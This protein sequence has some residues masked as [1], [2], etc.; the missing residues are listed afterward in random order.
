MGLQPG[1]CFFR[2]RPLGPTGAKVLPQLLLLEDVP[3]ELLR[4]WQRLHSQLSI[5][6]LAAFLI[7]PQGL[8][9]APRTPETADQLSMHFLSQAIHVEGLTVPGDAAV[10]VLPTCM[11]SRQHLQ[12]TQEY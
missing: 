3:I 2:R 9:P 5:Q 12:E 6:D 4:L 8:I 7:L 1:G 10:P 11:N